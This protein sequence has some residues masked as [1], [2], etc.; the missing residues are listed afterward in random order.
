MKKS[1]KNIGKQLTNTELTKYIEN[2]ETE[3][4]H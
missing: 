1:L 4:K 2:S 3:D